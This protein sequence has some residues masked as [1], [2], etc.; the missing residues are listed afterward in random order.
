MIRRA[1]IALSILACLPPV[2]QAKSLSRIIADAGLTPE[3]HAIMRD[4][5]R[6]LYTAANPPVGRILSWRNPESGSHGKVRLAGMRGNCAFI[7][8]FAYA[9]GQTTPY[10][11]RNQRCK[12]DDGRWL[13][14]P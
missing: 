11:I 14:V 12:S 5:A 9:A 1:L 4:T 13:L 7:Q 3:D 2:A 8:H 10:E 6:S